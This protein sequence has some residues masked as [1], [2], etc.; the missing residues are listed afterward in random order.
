MKEDNL[1]QFK[2]PEANTTSDLLTEITRQ[3]AREMLSA[4]LG[5][6]VQAFLELHQQAMPSGEPRLIRNGY[7]PRR[8]V[9]TGIG[10]LEIKAPRVRDRASLDKIKFNSAIVPPYLRRSRSM[11][12]FLPLLYL[13]GIS[14]GAFQESRAPLFGEQAN[15]LS[16]GVIS[17]LKTAWDSEYHEWYKRDLSKKVYVYWWV[18]EIYLQAR[19]ED[20]FQRLAVLL[21]RMIPKS[22]LFVHSIY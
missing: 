19:M 7:L 17:R 18:D 1:I 5:L 21:L 2:K 6:E 16:P 8:S 12:E 15:N 4:A 10:A 11:D 3:G 22:V 20:A 14:T 9:Q 13:K